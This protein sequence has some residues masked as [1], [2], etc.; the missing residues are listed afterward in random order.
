LE[1][2]RTHRLQIDGLR[3]I[4]VFGV[5][6]HH[7][8]NDSYIGH[9]GVRL[10]FV[11]SGLLITGILLEN[12]GQISEQGLAGVLKTFYA[13]R[14]LRIFPIYYLT[15]LGAFM[16]D[17][18]DV[19]DTF[20]WHALYLSNLLFAINEDW[21]W[22]TTHLWSL[23]IEEQFYLFWPFLVLLAPKKYIGAVF[24]MV[25]VG[26]VVFRA[27]YF[28]DASR[29]VGIWVATPA[30]FDALG[31]GALIAFW[32]R[33]GRYVPGEKTLK[34][35]LLP[36][37]VLGLL[38]GLLSNR[39][40]YV[41][42]ELMW[43]LPISILVAGANS[44]FNG[45]ASMILT[46]KPIVFLG[47]ISYGIYLYHFFVAWVLMQAWFLA[48]ASQISKGPFLFFL[49]SSATVLA[50]SLSWFWIEAPL[51]NLKKFFPYNKAAL[52]DE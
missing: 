33:S 27:F 31:V 36:A 18:G 50:A 34:I 44:G 2:A 3:A 17:I 35:A 26:A 5:L 13:R 4:A 23:S 1:P 40:N 7:L 20:T 45:V 16:I 43:L 14:A 22:P 9:L 6:Y 37:L 38:A 24:V 32:E 21:G 19:R 29:D 28:S 10:F 48:F 52:V 30:A 47:K 11:I 25:V 12:R 15:L 49:A 46:Y 51:S 8:W 41:W 39:S 42:G